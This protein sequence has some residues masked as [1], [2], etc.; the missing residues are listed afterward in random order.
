MSVNS[1][2]QT[3]LKPSI[4]LTLTILGGLHPG[5]MVVIQ[6]SVPGDADRFQVDFMCG[7][8]TK[9]RADVAF[10]FN[11][12]FKKNQIVCNTLQ[13]E[14]WGKE[15]IHYLMPFRKGA[16]FEIIILVEKDLYK[17]AVNGAHVLE[18]KHRM[19]LARVDTM[20][21]SGKVQIQAIGFIP[22]TSA[23]YSSSARNEISTQSLAVLDDS[24]DMSLPFKRKLIK[25]LSPG[26]TITV[27][28][29]IVNYAHSFNVNLRVGNSTDIALHLNPRLKSGLFIRNSYLSECW[30]PEENTLPSFPFTPGEYF[31]MIILCEAQQFKV[32][33]NGAHQLTYKHRVQD[34]SRV[35]E[36]EIT[37][38]LQLQDVKIW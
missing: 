24:G 20:S 4:P 12:R 8:S 28:G 2:K 14:Y 37:G 23:V 36:L 26:H 21:V 32:A 33:V 3:V 31:E 34:L 35:D 19:D 1:P 18:Y 27:K 7:S 6:G 22:S 29:H 10:H 16:D 38:D 30:G 11:P 25:G 5:E 15:E 13:L 9:P 17:V